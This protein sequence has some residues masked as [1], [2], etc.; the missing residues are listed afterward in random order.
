MGGEPEKPP[1]QAA[2]T[3]AAVARL[4]AEIEVGQCGPGQP[5]GQAARALAPRRI[6][7][8]DRNNEVTAERFA[9]AKSLVE[10]CLLLVRDGVILAVGTTA[11][12]RHVQALNLA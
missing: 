10:A 6:G 12:P 3:A 7:Q 11:H 9:E 8:R 1:E 2:A 5:I 4:H